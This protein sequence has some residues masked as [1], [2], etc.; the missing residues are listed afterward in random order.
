[1]DAVVIE[2]LGR[3]H[4]VTPPDFA[5]CEDLMVCWSSAATRGGIPLMRVAAAHIGLCTRLGRD[6]GGRY[7]ST[8]TVQYDLAGFGGTVYGYLRKRGVSVAE[9]MAAAQ[10]L[11]PVVTQAA[12]PRESEVEEAAKNSEAGAES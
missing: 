6:A 2:L 3:K 4:H 10:L 5:A 8:T 12:A 11:L 1:M 7:D 9:I